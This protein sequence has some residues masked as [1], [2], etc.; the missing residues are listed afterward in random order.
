[1]PHRLYARRSDQ[2]LIEVL[3]YVIAGV[4]NT[5]IGYGVFWIALRW[6]GYSPEAANATGYIIALSLAF[7]L[8]RFFVFTGAHISV[9]SSVR[10][11]VSFIAAFALNQLVLFLLVR[12]DSFLPETAQIFAMVVYTVSFYLFNK[13]FVF[14]EPNDAFRSKT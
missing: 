1:M 9:S 11:V 13:H 7:L 12:S 4:I 2:P 6:A 5:V 8:N 14:A 3:K 10:F